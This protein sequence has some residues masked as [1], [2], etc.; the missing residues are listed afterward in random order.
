MNENP[1]RSD[2]GARTDDVSTSFEFLASSEAVWQCL[3]FYEDVP[4][5]PRPLLRL[6]LP[7]PLR[8]QGDKRSPG[9]F[10]RCSYERGHLIKR[11]TNVEPARLLSFEVVEQGLGVE[12]YGRAHWGS[13]ELEPCG[14][15]TRLTLTTAYS[16]LMRPRWLWRPLERYLC[17]RMHDHI[18]LGM[19]ERLAAENRSLLTLRGAVRGR[20]EPTVTPSR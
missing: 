20:Q 9:S 12:R 3:M 13:Y 17:H 7:L 8:S 1:A 16:G 15:G 14:G 2:Q 4:R 11:I 10:V 5:R 6:F 18:L 19:R